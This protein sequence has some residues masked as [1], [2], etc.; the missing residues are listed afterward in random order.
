MNL[1]GAGP[2]EQPLA[3]GNN[4]PRA[5]TI[6]ET[7]VDYG[8]DLITVVT[9]GRKRFSRAFRGSIAE[10]IIAEAPCPVL[11]TKSLER[12]FVESSGPQTQLNLKR[13]VLAT[14]FRP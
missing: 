14:N 7:A 3:S 2:E 4:S 9:R 1:L 13:I 12:D 5:E 6:A 10:D 8:I 11:A